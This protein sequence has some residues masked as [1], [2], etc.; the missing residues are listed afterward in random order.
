ML[1]L[2]GFYSNDSSQTLS[3]RLCFFPKFHNHAG[4]ADTDIADGVRGTGGVGGDNLHVSYYPTTW[5][6]NTV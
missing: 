1:G 2:V 5:V 6:A 4:V 3:Y